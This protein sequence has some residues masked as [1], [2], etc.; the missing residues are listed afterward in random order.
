VPGPQV[1]TGDFFMGFEITWAGG[2]VFSGWDY[3]ASPNDEAY[4]YRAEP[5]WLNMCTHYGFC[6]AFT[7]CVQLG[8]G[9]PQKE[10]IPGMGLYVGIG[11][12]ADDTQDVLD[13]AEKENIKNIFIYWVEFDASGIVT[14]LEPRFVTGLEGFIDRLREDPATEDCMIHVVAGGKRR[15]FGQGPNKPDRSGFLH[16]HFETI[17][18]EVRQKVLEILPP[19]D[20]ICFDIEAN[21]SDDEVWFTGYA[22]LVSC[23]RDDSHLLSVCLNEKEV[24]SASVVQTVKESDFFVP[25][26]YWAAAYSGPRDINSL[27][28]LSAWCSEAD[29]L[30]TK[31]GTP[32]YIA[33]GT[34]EVRWTTSGE[35]QEL[36][37]EGA[38]SDAYRHLKDNREY[39]CAASRW[40]RWPRD[41]ANVIW[42]EPGSRS[43]EREPVIWKSA[44]DLRS[45]I[46]VV[47]ANRGEWG[48]GILDHHYTTTLGE[49]WFAFRDYNLKDDNSNGLVDEDN[50]AELSELTVSAEGGLF[51]R[52]VELEIGNAGLRPID[53]VFFSGWR[54]AVTFSKETLNDIQ[55]GNDVRRVTV[56]FRSGLRLGANIFTIASSGDAVES[57][58]GIFKLLL[59]SPAD[60]RIT[61]AEGRVTGISGEETIEEIPGSMYLGGD[62][63]PKTAILP[64][65]EPFYEIEVIPWPEANPED[66]YSLYVVAGDDTLVLAEHVMIR[67]I[68]EEP[69]RLECP[70]PLADIDVNPHTLNASSRGRW[71]TCYIE[72]PEEY[73][74]SD[75]DVA[76]L[77]FDGAVPAEAEPSEIGDFDKDGI[78]DLMVKFDRAGVQE[79]LQ[80]G[81]SVEVVI[82]GE[83]EDGTMF[84]GLDV[85]RVM[86]NGGPQNVTAKSALPMEFSL[87][88]NYPNPFRETTVLRF[89]VPLASGV[90][91]TVYDVAG[92]L[93]VSL[94]DDQLEPGYYTVEW[95][96]VDQAGKRVPAGVYLIE[97]RAGSFATARKLL[98][99]H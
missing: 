96:G 62:A 45:G 97:L 68:P 23:L 78:P 89:A 70:I 92:R 56:L 35:R 11:N 57:H 53:E 34:F 28:T 22:E 14:P 88:Q 27:Q 29:E 91:L 73:D 58:L 26:Y 13:R 87:G 3:D 52:I 44:S 2:Y 30:A 32:C 51:R 36:G 55:P 21:H 7:Q 76:S 42:L 41:A 90:R 82:S 12:V 19:V 84:A 74:V 77:M 43:S 24:R 81:D 8:P 93:V 5:P 85:I 47:K 60:L 25:M 67:D 80:A 75:I 48:L 65:L 79:I 16:E 66:V 94:V 31:A 61:D 59:F 95:E 18:D 10:P 17:C 50:E 1:P 86:F 33:V 54:D 15:D 69:Y 20:G 64:M 37:V 4:W 49:E 99:T 38:P 9:V 72:S 39:I 40:P 46:D 83:L 6:G 63:E 98:R 71:I